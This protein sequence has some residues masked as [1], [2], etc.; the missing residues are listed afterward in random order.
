M[1]GDAK[2]TY[3]TA[4]RKAEAAHLASTSRAE[5][6]RATGI[7]KAKATNAVQASKLQQQHQEAMQNLEEE[8]LKEEKFTHQSF[9]W[10]CE[11][12]LQACPN[13]ALAKLMYPL[14]LLMGSPSLPRPLMVTS[15]LTA[16]S[17]NSVTS[18][19]P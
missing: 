17:R 5:V 1:I 4:I 12:A 18:P 6:T 3:G 9:L 15:P 13:D 14:H 19:S 11:G 16:R 7:R 10:T 8:A 2:T